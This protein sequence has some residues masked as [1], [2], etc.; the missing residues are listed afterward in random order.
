MH[1]AMRSAKQESIQLLLDAGQIFRLF[2][3]MAKQRSITPPIKIYKLF[4]QNYKRAP[5]H[6]PWNKALLTF[7]IISNRFIGGYTWKKRRTLIEKS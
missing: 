2:L 7:P 1:G 6:K 5:A 3:M 4:V